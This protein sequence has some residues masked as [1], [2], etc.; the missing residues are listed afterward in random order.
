MIGYGRRPAGRAEKNRIMLTHLIEAIL[1]HHA[2]MFLV[3][4]AAP[5]VFVKLQCKTEFARGGFE[6]T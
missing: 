1:R 5:V 4:V 3:V 6:N 2:A